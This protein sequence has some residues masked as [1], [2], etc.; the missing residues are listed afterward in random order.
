MDDIGG[1]V[2]T[3]TNEFE[4]IKLSKPGVKASNYWCMRKGGV[5]MYEI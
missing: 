4:E 1:C 3:H 2:H 5:F